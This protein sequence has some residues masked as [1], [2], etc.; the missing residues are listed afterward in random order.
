M[1]RDGI[2]MEAVH[3]LSA[4]EI[5]RRSAAMAAELGATFGRLQSELLSPL[6]ER[7]ECIVARSRDP[8]PRVPDDVQ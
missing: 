2:D 6:A 4:E 3:R 7:C 5:N 8:L 1:A